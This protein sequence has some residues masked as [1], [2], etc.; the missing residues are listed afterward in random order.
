[1]MNVYAVKDIK[2]QLFNN[3][4]IQKSDGV[5]I[6]AFATACEDTNTDL[7]KYPS[8]FSLYHIGT[9]D[10]ETGDL[11]Q[12]DKKQVANA[13]EFVASVE[14]IAEKAKQIREEHLED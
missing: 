14:R 7:N 9:Y 6:R 13:S 11:T 10:P 2:S 12:S 5:A 4:F 3:P 8:D 1:M